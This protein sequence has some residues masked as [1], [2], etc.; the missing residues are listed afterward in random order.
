MV[1]MSGAW[2]WVVPKTA[3]WIRSG[4]PPS[5]EVMGLCGAGGM[6]PVGKVV[7]L[8]LGSSD[9]DRSGGWRVVEARMSATC[10]PKRPSGP[11]TFLERD[12]VPAD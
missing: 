10:C 11:D 6:L 1:I 2:S 3:A 9:D 4:S 7:E 12:D 8:E 5:H